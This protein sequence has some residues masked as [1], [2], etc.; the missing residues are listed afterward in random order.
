MR[1][2]EKIS[3]LTD[4]KMF[5]AIINKEL[6]VKKIPTSPITYGKTDITTPT[7]TTADRS[8]FIFNTGIRRPPDLKMREHNLV[9][10]PNTTSCS[11]R[12]PQTALI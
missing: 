4:V 11:L 5:N 6:D 10:R 7:T 8:K 12:S 3:R 9:V 1:L 2:E